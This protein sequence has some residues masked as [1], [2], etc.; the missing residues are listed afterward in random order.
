MKKSI[1]LLIVSVVFLWSCKGA[2]YM[3]QRYTNFGHGASKSS[4]HAVAAHHTVPA[5]QV[6]ACSVAVEEG[7]QTAAAGKAPATPT[8]EQV[9]AP[10]ESTRP[11]S[12][13]QAKQ[14]VSNALKNATTK[15]G[16]E[17]KKGTSDACNRT[18]AYCPASLA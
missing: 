11:A 6:A 3:K 16:F 2:S 14:L 18:E 13:K 12:E 7:V 9:A 4:N 1:Y 5:Q 15:A 17:K 8:T 10:K